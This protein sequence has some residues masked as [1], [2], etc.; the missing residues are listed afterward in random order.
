MD[1]LWARTSSIYSVDKAKGFNNPASFHSQPLDKFFYR[2]PQFVVNILRN[3]E[4]KLLFYMLA[5]YWPLGLS[6]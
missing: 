1:I 4:Q 2:R 6:G 3:E 5:H